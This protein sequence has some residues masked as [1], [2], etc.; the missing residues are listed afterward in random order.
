MS[1]FFF[2]HSVFKRLVSQGHQKVSLCGNG[3]PKQQILDSSKLKEDYDTFK[4]DENGRKFFK[5]SKKK[6]NTV[7]KE[8]LLVTS[9]FSLSHS[10]FLKTFT[11][12]IKKPGLFWKGF[13][14]LGKKGFEY[15]GGKNK[16]ILVSCIFSFSHNVF[17]P[18]KDQCR[19]L[20]NTCSYYLQKFVL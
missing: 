17:L 1:N 15:I 13:T 10:L 11:T 9:N 7:K 5:K 14:A 6:K 20:S 3:F 19:H 16:K 4:F 18:I 12:D 2:S 8:K